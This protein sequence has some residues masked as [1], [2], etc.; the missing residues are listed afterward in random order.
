MKFTETLI[1]ENSGDLIIALGVFSLSLLLSILFCKMASFNK[2]TDNFFKN[3][4]KW[5]KAAVSLFTVPLVLLFLIMLIRNSSVL[6][7]TLLW[8]YLLV[9]LNNLT[10]I[11]TV[12]RTFQ[13]EIRLFVLVLSVLLFSQLNSLEMLPGGLFQTNLLVLDGVLESFITVII[14]AFIVLY[15]RSMADNA[16]YIILSSLLLQLVC[17]CYFLGHGLVELSFVPLVFAGTY[18]SVLIGSGFNK[19]LKQSISKSIAVYTGFVVVFILMFFVTN[20][21]QVE[22]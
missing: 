18:A 15:Y 16:L 14:T 6:L 11:L 10:Y 4:T 8:F 22:L 3:E 13:K 17:S 5:S 19:E 2:I 7:L 20:I 1:R 12:N 21:A 9:S